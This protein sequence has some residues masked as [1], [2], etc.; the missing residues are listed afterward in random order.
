M[1]T[2]SKVKVRAISASQI[3]NA[4]ERIVDNGEVVKAVD[5]TFYNKGKEIEPKKNVSVTFTSSA[6]KGLNKAKVV[7]IKDSGAAE[8][9]SG[10]S[11]SSGKASFKSDDF[12]IYAVVE[13]GEDARLEVIFMNG[14]SKVASTIVKKSDIDA[15]TTTGGSLFDQLV[16]DPGAGS[17]GSGEVFRGWTTDPDYT[18]ADKDS[19]LNISKVRTAVKAK[20]NEG[21]TES[22][23]E[24]AKM[25]FYAM[26][27]KAINIT[28]KDEDGVVIKNV[29]ELTKTEDTVTHVVDEPYVPKTSDQEFQG[30]YFTTQGTITDEDGDAIA[31][32]SVIK[33]GTTVKI[34]SDLVLSVNAPKGFWLIFKENAKGASYT[35]PQFLEN[36]KP[37]I[38]TDPTLFG[39]TFGGWYED[40]DCTD[41][42]E[43]NFDQVLEKTTIVYAKWIENETAGYNIII[44][45]Q[46]AGDA[47]NAADSAK[48]YDFAE[49]ISGE[50]NVGTLINDVTATGTGN[51][52][53]A[54]VNGTAKKYTGFHLN[55]YDT[56]VTI[57]VNGTSVVN[58]Y[59][60]RNLVTL[61]FLYRNNNEW[62][63][64]TT[65]TGLYGQTLS[66][67]DYTWPTNLW[68][69]SSYNYTPGWGG[70]SYSGSGTRTTFMDAFITSDG[71]SEQT[72]YGFAGSGTRQI[73]FY[74]KNAAGNYVLTNT[75]TT[76]T[77]TGQ[78]TPTFYISDKYNGYKPVQYRYNQGGGPGGGWTDWIDIGDEQDEHGY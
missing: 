63:T 6:F 3:E 65:M 67:N 37:E 60:D 43:F 38:P 78:Q 8:R 64:Q 17:L 55:K 16:Y 9:V 73:R 71:S 31:E 66:Q 47:K 5:I 58:V 72:F 51:D 27:F 50:G 48:T 23:G 18:V 61:K 52:R 19:G 29:A 33:N 28:Y 12:S 74:K 1:P 42:K 35:S 53:Y 36:E 24:P 59:Y 40:A 46:N 41:G 26:T 44:W 30:W 11:V 15:T 22:G 69:Y 25:Y 4:V 2:D 49:S 75:V 76:T 54:S 34:T 13:E 7:H 14:D 32:G 62:A 56:N 70:G 21:V 45:K 20:L 10:S 68:W 57:D 39:H 77:A